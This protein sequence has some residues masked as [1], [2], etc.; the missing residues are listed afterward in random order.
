[1]M[2]NNPPMN[3]VIG[4]AMTSGL[5]EGIGALEMA[6]PMMAGTAILYCAVKR[7]KDPKLQWPDMEC[8]IKTYDIDSLFQRNEVPGNRDGFVCCANNA[9]RQ[10][11]K[12]TFLQPTE[13][14]RRLNTYILDSSIDNFK[15]L[16]NYVMEDHR[17]T[18]A[19][20]AQ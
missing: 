1:M 16:L 18:R 9:L 7:F 2:H 13:F 4:Y 5:Y 8:L 12:R 17:R 10:G 19:V 14:D 6:K 15:S 3:G 20:A 11:A